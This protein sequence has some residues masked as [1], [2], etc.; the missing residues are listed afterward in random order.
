MTI[1]WQWQFC[2]N[3]TILSRQYYDNIV[4]IRQYM[5]IRWRAKKRKRNLTLVGIEPWP[6]WLG[7]SCFPTQPTGT[8]IEFT[9]LTKFYTWI[10]NWIFIL[11]H[12][13]LNFVK[14]TLSHKLSWQY[15]DI[16]AKLSLSQNCHIL[17][18][19]FMGDDGNHKWK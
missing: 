11:S 14:T 2:N 13:C 5:I 3:V 15:S 4:T 19:L 18:S 1:L 10:W 7:G 16:V 8:C 17:D 12:Y 6:S 9:S